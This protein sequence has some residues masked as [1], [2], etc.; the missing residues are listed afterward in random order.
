MDSRDRAAIL[1]AGLPQ[2][3]LYLKPWNPR[4]TQTENC[5]ELQYRWDNQR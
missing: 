2:L 3:N 4:T 5:Y 1:L